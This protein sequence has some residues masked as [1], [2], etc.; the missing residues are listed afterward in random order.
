MLFVFSSANA[1]NITDWR[2]NDDESFVKEEQEDIIKKW[3]KNSELYK[4]I[5]HPSEINIFSNG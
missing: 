5:K 3:N 1:Y 2:Q 4:V